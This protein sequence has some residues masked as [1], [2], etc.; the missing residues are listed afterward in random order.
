MINIDTISLVHS[1][2][3]NKN[4]KLILYLESDQKIDNY[5][6]L[7]FNGKGF[8]G[9][10]FSKKL[11]NK[12]LIQQEEFG[13]I[14]VFSDS[15]SFIKSIEEGFNLLSLKIG[16]EQNNYLIP[17]RNTRT[18]WSIDNLLEL[19]DSGKY[20]KIDYTMGACFISCSKSSIMMRNGFVKDVYW[21]TDFS[22]I[23]QYQKMDGTI[24][25]QNEIDG[26]FFYCETLNLIYV[27]LAGG[28][29][30]ALNTENGEIIWIKEHLVRRDGRLTSG[31]YGIFGD[32]I[33]KTD[34][35]SII[36]LSAKTGEILKK[37]YFEDI[38]DVLNEIKNLNDNFI[39]SGPINIYD[40]LLVLFSVRK[41]QIIVLSRKS[42]ELE[43]FIHIPNIPG[44]PNSKDSIAWNNNKLYVLDMDNILHIFKKE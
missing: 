29:L 1:F 33:Y 42:F 22:E 35:L 39:C 31:K 36:E 30:V 6:Y 24:A 28:Q 44:I 4:G 34:G 19:R 40:D 8:F 18:L 26:E 7:N 38:Q 20:C 15:G 21:Q 2:I 12:L 13:E 25:E 14:F 11:F 3:V 37:L 9:K 41:S 43:E 23:G 10:G 32:S 5:K 17:N 27:P 16:L